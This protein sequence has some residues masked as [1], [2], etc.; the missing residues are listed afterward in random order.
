MP[1]RALYEQL[2]LSLRS[3]L[4]F[5]MFGVPGSPRDSRYT[6]GSGYLR[7]IFEGYV[8]DTDRRELRR[9]AELAPIAP[10]V[11]DILVYLIRNRERVVSKDDLIT[12]IWDGRIVSDSALTTRLNGA[13]NAVGDSGNEQRLIKTFPRKG[14]RFV[15]VVREEKPA[16]ALPVDHETRPPGAILA[17]P[18]KPSIAVLPFAN[19]SGD[20]LQDYFTDGVVEDIITELSRFSELFVIARNSSFTYKARSVD[21]R[22]VGRD[23]G[24]RYVL[25]GS[26]RK[27]A[28]R[29]RMTGQLIDAATGAHIWADRFESELEDI[30]ALQDQMAESVVGAI[31]PRLELAEIERAKSKPT[32]NLNAYDC[33]LR[34]MAAWHDWTQSSHNNALKL[35]YQATEIDP[36]FGRPYALAAGCYLMRKANGWVVD[37]VTEIA[38]TER[39]AKLAANLGRTDAVALAWSGHALAHVVGDIDTGI[40]LVDRALLLNANLAMAWHRSGWLRIYAGECELA[41]VH[42]ER[43]MRLSPL[44]PL[45]HLANSATAFAYF[46]LED[47]EEASVWAERAVQLRS[48][49]PPALRVLAMSHALAGREQAARQALT[50]L[51]L[52][53]PQLRVSN[54]HEQIFLHRPEHMA[55]CKAAMRT[56]GLPE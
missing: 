19:L 53:Q 32:D 36:E 35:F 47:L 7:Y 25:E 44:D 45:R 41:I 31:V 39:L 30:F 52:V 10:Q 46:L 8:L 13:R 37:R 43:S 28:N 56:A 33:F 40:A 24:V 38:E 51:A 16:G 4:F 48:N 6:H 3:S 15:G 20:T 22:D 50:R 9:G 29:V 34:G 54:L 23:L 1:A 21:V 49:W 17:L 11:F 18:D 26:V 27:V 12:A 5:A 14:I 55:K 2:T 42:L